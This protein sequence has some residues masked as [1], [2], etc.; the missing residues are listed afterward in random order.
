MPN[1]LVRD[2]SMS[3]LS[4]DPQQRERQLANLRRGGTNPGGGRPIEFGGYAK[5]AREQVA[6]HER[7]ILDV[8]AAS[9]PVR[10]AHG[11]V[12]VADQ[13][14][15]VLLAEARCRLTM[16]KAALDAW[17]FSD[18]RGN[19][20]NAVALEGRLRRECLRYAEQLGMTP[21]AR[22]RLGLAVTPE[23]PPS[24]DPDDEAERRAGLARLEADEEDRR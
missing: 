18:Q 16:V 7:E 13:M 4:S 10:S 17:P 19:Y 9:A 12:P 11:G 21:A 23:D 20:A 15:V 24:P 1:P 22:H 14:V 2:A 3:P 8:I 6:E 5:L